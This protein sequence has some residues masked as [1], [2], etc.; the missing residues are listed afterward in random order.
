MLD[1]RKDIVLVHASGARQKNFVRL[2]PGDLVE[3]SLS[4]HDPGRGRL[5]RVL[6]G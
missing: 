2:R 3:V 1:N 4:P 5:L 6:K